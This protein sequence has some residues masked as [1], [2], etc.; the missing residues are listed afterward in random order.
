MGAKSRV[1]T[2]VKLTVQLVDARVRG[3]RSVCVCIHAWQTHRAVQGHRVSGWS[4][5]RLPDSCL[6]RDRAR[7]TASRMNS[8]FLSEAVADARGSRGSMALLIGVPTEASTLALDAYL[9][10]ASAPTDR[11]AIC[12]NCA[13]REVRM[14]DL[15]L[16]RACLTWV[17]A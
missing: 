14:C 7:S 10:C 9:V 15:R 3:G 16:S 13:N 12:T 4:A 8:T 1:E 2:H 17:G 6:V 11:I 5:L